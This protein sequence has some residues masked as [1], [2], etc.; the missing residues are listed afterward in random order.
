MSDARDL[1]LG[2]GVASAK[3]ATIGDFVQGTIVAIH[4][5]Q[6]SRKFRTDGKLGDLEYWDDLKTQPIYQV[7]IDLQTIVRDPLIAYDDGIRGVYIRAS[8][9]TQRALA[10]AVRASGAT[11]ILVGAVLGIQFI[12]E[13]ETGAGSPKKLYTAVYVPPASGMIMQGAPAPAAPAPMPA[14]PVQ[15]A[16]AAPAA[17]PAMAVPATV[18]PTVGAAEQL[19]AARAVYDIPAPHPTMTFPQG[20]PGM[21]AATSNPADSPEV[22]AL[23]ARVENPTP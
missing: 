9:E 3:F 5:K 7:R 22:Q 19:A 4:D 15:T 21:A 13:E 2:S 14:P 18:A 10:V 20:Q 11:D 12:G 6:Q 8:S 17:L 16:P 23:L 1:I